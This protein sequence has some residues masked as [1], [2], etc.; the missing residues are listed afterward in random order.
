MKWRIHVRII[1]IVVQL[2]STNAAACVEHVYMQASY[3]SISMTAFVHLSKIKLVTLFHGEKKLMYIFMF[4]RTRCYTHNLLH[5]YNLC[6]IFGFAN[7]L[8]TVFQAFIL[9]SVAYLTE[10]QNQIAE[11]TS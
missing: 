3:R 4:I 1:I 8:N 5:F 9:L 11:N 6:K 10:T 2:H 7:C